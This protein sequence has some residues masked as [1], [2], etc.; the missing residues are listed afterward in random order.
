M[1]KSQVGKHSLAIDTSA[2]RIA[3]GPMPIVNE[4]ELVTV[5]EIRLSNKLTLPLH[6]LATSLTQATL[7]EVKT[8]G[9]PALATLSIRGLGSQHCVLLWNGFNLQNSMH[10]TT[11]VSLVGLYTPAQELTL[12]YGS[13]CA[14]DG[15]GAVAGSLSISDKAMSTDGLQLSTGQTMGSFGYR[16]HQL[17]MGFAQKSSYIQM[18]Y[19]NEFAKNNYWYTKNG[20]SDRAPIRLKNATSD[21]HQFNLS[22]R[23]QLKHGFSLSGAANYAMANRQIP[24]TESQ[25]YNRSFQQ[26]KQLKSYLMLLKSKKSTE[27]AISTGYF[28][29]ELKYTDP[30]SDLVSLSKIHKL[31]T[32]FSFNQS[33]AKLHQLGC[34]LENNFASAVTSNYKN[35]VG[36]QNIFSFMMAYRWLGVH[37]KTILAVEIRQSLY[38][39]KV[40]PFLFD[41]SFTYHPIRLVTLQV[42][43]ARIYRIP[44][45]NDLYWNPG[46]NKNL[47][48]EKGWHGEWMWKLNYSKKG[49]EFNNAM[50]NFYYF[51]ENWIVWLPTTKGYWVPQNI[52]TVFSR[53]LQE[54]VNVKMNQSKYWIAVRLGYQFNL[55][56]QVSSITSNDASLGKQL[57]YEPLHKVYGGLQMNFRGFQI[58]YSHQFTSK[59]FTSSDNVYA[60]PSFQT[61]NLMLTKTFHSTQFDFTMSAVVENLYNT[62]YYMIES[63]PMPGRNFKIGV[64]FKCH[65]RVGK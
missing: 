15:S 32:K 59:R 39:Q 26:D 9:T 50:S 44:T 46:G 16:S 61:A 27:I 5:K 54:E 43:A 60:L 18:S 6:A 42:K 52:K 4:L 47:L 62:K 34:S 8:Y 1:S 45:L 14:R 64:I 19:T 10:G 37:K 53:G 23:L 63:R 24:P 21:I 31:I 55:S 48:P 41:L 2:L 58:D 29:D 33:F 3:D 40:S 65:N 36:R 35:G 13:S 49:F 7:V 20:A 17:Y 25:S 57:I 30:L 28:Y 12:T 22:G 56:T 51:V 38:N 11:D